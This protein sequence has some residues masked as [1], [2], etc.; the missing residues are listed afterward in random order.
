MA[1]DHHVLQNGHVLKEADVLEGPGESSLSDLVGAETRDILLRLLRRTNHYVAARGWMHTGDAVKDRCLS[2]SVRSN[3][4]D[5]LT[6]LDLD[7]DMIDGAQ[8]SKLLPG[9]FDHP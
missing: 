7:I 9:F 1:T 3:Q 6:G 2:R 4:R 8:A 5:D